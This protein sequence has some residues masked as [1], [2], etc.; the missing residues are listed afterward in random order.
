M[1]RGFLLQVNY[2]IESSVKRRFTRKIVITSPQ[3]KDIYCVNRLISIQCCFSACHAHRT[4]PKSDMRTVLCADPSKPPPI[5]TRVCVCNLCVC[6]RTH[7]H[8][9]C[10]VLK[11]RRRPIMTEGVLKLTKHIDTLRKLL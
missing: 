11:V 10:T 2:K 6:A 1:L 3:W 7:R 5:Y 4:R 8:T 9:N